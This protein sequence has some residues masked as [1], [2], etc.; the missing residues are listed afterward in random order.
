[1][2][3]HGCAIRR[4]GRRC[5]A[6]HEDAAER[7]LERPTTWRVIDGLVAVV[8]VAVAATLALG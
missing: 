4:H 6:A 2:P 3:E 7:G 8:M 5:A 1:M